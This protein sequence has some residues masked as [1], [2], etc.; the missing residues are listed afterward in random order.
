MAT[1]EE[2]NHEKEIEKEREEEEEEEQNSENFAGNL[3]YSNDALMQ[4]VFPFCNAVL[5]LFYYQNLICFNY[6]I[7]I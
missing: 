7:S 1:E 6:N 2:K 3:N 4:M 5:W